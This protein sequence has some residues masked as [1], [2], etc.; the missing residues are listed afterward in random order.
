MVWLG[1]LGGAGPISETGS[2]IATPTILGV[3]WRLY[4]GPGPNNAFTVFSFVADSS[5]SQFSG[6]L[7]E[8]FNYVATFQGVSWNAVV[9]SL[10]AGTEPFTGTLFVKYVEGRRCSNVASRLKCCL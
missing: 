3:N 5:I 9:T 10:Q 7:K 1:A 6:D 4:K 8:F 2:P